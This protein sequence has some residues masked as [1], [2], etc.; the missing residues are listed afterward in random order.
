MSLRANLRRRLRLALLFYLP[1]LNSGIVIAL[2]TN[3]GDGSYSSGGFGDASG[4]AL[5]AGNN[6]A[7]LVGSF[8]GGIAVM[9]AIMLIWWLWQYYK[10]QRARQEAGGTR[11]C[12]VCGVI[13]LPVYTQTSVEGGNQARPGNEA[14][15]A[16][17]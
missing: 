6:T 16:A 2:K 13:A 5:D 14:S 12:P 7:E 1:L 15:F 11:K 8:F 10:R 17:K 9:V 4:R 3:S